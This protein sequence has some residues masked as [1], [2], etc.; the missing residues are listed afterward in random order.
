M[1]DIRKTMQILAKNGPMVN[2][3]G[4]VHMV[5]LPN[6][7]SVLE[8]ILIQNI[9]F[10]FIMQSVIGGLDPNNIVMI[11]NDLPAAKEMAEFLLSERILAPNNT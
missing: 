11:T 6:K 7:L 3:F 1:D 10:T 5:T 2:R 8:D 9:D 4:K